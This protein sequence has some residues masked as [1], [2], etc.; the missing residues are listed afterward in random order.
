[1]PQYAAPVR[2]VRFVLD[3]VIG[4][5][6]YSNL[7]GFENATPDMVNA[8]LEEGGKFMAE[9]LFPLNRVGDEQGCT[10][11]ADGTVRTPDGFK[12]AY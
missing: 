10:R 7:P 11:H 3:H 1:M 5:D 4:L 6:R 2:D 8:I 12:A 9:V